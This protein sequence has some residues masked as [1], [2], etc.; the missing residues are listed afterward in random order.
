MDILVISEN[1]I[2][3]FIEEFFN[4]KKINF[5]IARGSIHCQ[6]ILNTKKIQRILFFYTSSTQKIEKELIQVINQKSIPVALFFET[7]EENLSVQKSSIT[8]YY[9]DIFLDET[10]TKI[11]DKILSFLQPITDKTKAKK[12][13]NY[14]FKNY[15]AKFKKSTAQ[16]AYINQEALNQS[17]ETKILTLW[18][19]SRNELWVKGATSG[20]TF[21]ITKIKVNCEQDSLLFFV[22]KNKQGICHTLDSHGKNRISCFYR[23]IDFENPTKLI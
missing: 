12:T 16:I 21:Q 8:R 23:E 11:L 9:C 3:Q 15:F 18:S 20:N 14:L 6:S 10:Q 1:K 7:S 13:N 17:L 2:L 19:S 22:R 5:F 4:H